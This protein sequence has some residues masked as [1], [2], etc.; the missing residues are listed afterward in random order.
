MKADEADVMLK[1]MTVAI[2]RGVSDLLGSGEVSGE[3]MIKT[4]GD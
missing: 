4:G 1:A 2:N 3:E